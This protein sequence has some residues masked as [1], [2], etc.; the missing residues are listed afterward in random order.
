M[1]LKAF[2]IVFVSLSTLLA[3]G[4]GVWTLREPAGAYRW[5]GWISLVLA[6]LFPV[7][8]WWFLRKMKGVDLW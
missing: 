3:L 4:F 7:Y 5:L 6:V 1:S 2:H 8:G